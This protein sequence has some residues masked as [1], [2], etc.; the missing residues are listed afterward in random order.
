MF[1]A[2]QCRCPSWGKSLLIL[3][4]LNVPHVEEVLFCVAKMQVKPWQYRYIRMPSWLPE[5]VQ[6]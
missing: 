3:R 1:V 2:L 6:L 4:I 5:A